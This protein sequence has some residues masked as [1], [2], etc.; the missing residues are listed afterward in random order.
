MSFQIW[1]HLSFFFTFYFP[2]IFFFCLCAP[3]CADGHCHHVWVAF[4]Q[5]SSSGQPGRGGSLQE[6]TAGGWQGGRK[7]TGCKRAPWWLDVEKR[8]HTGW[9]SSQRRTG[10]SPLTLD[11]RRLGGHNLRLEFCSG[12]TGSEFGVKTMRTW[13]HPASCERSRQRCF[14]QST[15]M[16]CLTV[17]TPS[18][19]PWT[20]F[21]WINR[22]E[23]VSPG[24]FARYFRPVLCFGATT[25]NDFQQV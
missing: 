18:W 15:W 22:K 10:N 7:R 23:N 6:N 14:I 12:N 19:P 3:D 20:I 17:F 21:C 2:F 1:V 9:R 24:L 4:W 25:S 13:I 5:C 11:D 8:K 16:L